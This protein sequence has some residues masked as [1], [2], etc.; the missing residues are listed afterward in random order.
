MDI[1]YC[2]NIIIYSKIVFKRKFNLILKNNMYQIY[3]IQF[4]IYSLSVKIDSV[5][6]KGNGN[7]N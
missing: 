7:N 3:I 4:L 1:K 6:N 2:Y 5:D